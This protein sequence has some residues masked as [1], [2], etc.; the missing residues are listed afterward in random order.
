MSDEGPRRGR[1][2]PKA[3]GAQFGRLT[4]SVEQGTITALA[5]EAQRRGVSLSELTRTA[6]VEWMRRELP[7]ARMP[8]EAQTPRSKGEDSR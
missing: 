2:R 7:A 8:H 5:L 6:L 3:I 4:V 1:E